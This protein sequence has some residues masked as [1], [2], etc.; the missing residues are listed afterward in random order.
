MKAKRKTSIFT[1]LVLILIVLVLW[2]QS[3]NQTTTQ[4]AATQSAKIKHEVK[5][6]KKLSVSTVEKEKFKKWALQNA[7]VTYLEYPDNSDWQ[8]WVKL[9]PEKYTTKEN[10]E[11]IAL[12]LA[13]GYKLQTGFENLVSVSVWHLNKSE[14]VAKGRL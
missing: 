11:K 3:N 12:S 14:I 10:I 13:R 4:Q 1:W 2:S 8:I 9:K 7:S 6:E 5:S